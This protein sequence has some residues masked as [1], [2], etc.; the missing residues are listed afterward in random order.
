MNNPNPNLA[1]DR[2]PALPLEP[3]LDQEGIFELSLFERIEGGMENPPHYAD[4]HSS[5]LES[6]SS[7]KYSKSKQVLFVYGWIDVK[8]VFEEYQVGL[9]IKILLGCSMLC[10]IRIWGHKVWPVL[11]SVWAVSLLYTGYYM[12]QMCAHLKGH[13]KLRYIYTVEFNFSLGYLIV[14]SGLLITFLGLIP[15]H[16]LGWFV[17]PLFMISLAMVFF[18]NEQ[19]V[20]LSRKSFVTLECIQFLLIAF[21]ISDP[22]SLDWNLVLVIYSASSAFL[23]VLGMLL[24]VLVS[25]A[26]FGFVYRQLPAWK[27]RSLAW[28]T[29]Y[30]LLT[31]LCY[32]YI[33]KGVS[34]Y[35]S[36]ADFITRG[37]IVSYVSYSNQDPE[38]LSSAAVMLILFNGLLL[39]LQLVFKKDLMKYL[40]KVIFP[41]DLRTEVSVRKFKPPFIF[42]II[43]S[44]SVFFKKHRPGNVEKFQDNEVFSDYF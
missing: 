10:N 7:S 3:H 26:L 43:Q 16:F 12:M 25:C 20:F 18:K 19:N 22:Q 29:L 28:L 23:C 44:S 14:Y 21:K 8:T 37:Q 32:I 24:T 33:I 40:A 17:V 2:Q 1:I 5:K 11:A 41:K 35:Y 31:G 13:P 36:D 30:Y 4:D 39:A 9:I 42:K 38:I 27:V 15:V 34:E 6:V